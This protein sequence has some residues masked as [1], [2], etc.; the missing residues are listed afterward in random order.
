MQHV[1]GRSGLDL[2]DHVIVLPWQH[3]S[4]GT[5]F[6]PRHPYVEQFWL[7]ILGPSAVWFLRRI[8]NGF[9][10]WP[11]GFELDRQLTATA[12]GLND[13][14]RQSSLAR[15]VVRLTQFQLVKPEGPGLMVRRTVP[16]L[17]REQVT[18]LHKTL[19]DAHA[20][21]LRPERLLS[22]Q[23]AVRVAASLLREGE[24]PEEAQRVLRTLGYGEQ[25]AEVSVRR[26][27]AYLARQTQAAS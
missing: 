13:N 22:D 1:P 11:D 4:R 25:L 17:S 20:E 10:S 24:W 15:T 6:D 26:A 9:D 27:E 19:R 14:G 2:D 3:V 7:G 8:A 18:R 12:L 5:G 23:R 16:C 21:W